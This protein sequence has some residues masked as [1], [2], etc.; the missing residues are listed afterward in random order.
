MAIRILH[1]VIVLACSV[2]LSAQDSPPAKHASGSTETSAEP[3][4]PDGAIRRLGDTR[5][6]PGARIK[7]LAFSPDGSRLVSWGNWLY[8][9]DRLSVWD[10][11]TGREVYTSPQPEGELAD[12]GWGADG[13]FAVFPRP[14]GFHLWAFADAAGKHPPEAKEAAAKAAGMGIVAQAATPSSTTT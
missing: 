14:N 6:R 5:F 11:A 7:H 3:P 2:V 8:F 4:L 9:G 1:V 12:L 13:G 10:T